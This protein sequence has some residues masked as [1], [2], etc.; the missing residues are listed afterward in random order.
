MQVLPAAEAGAG[1]LADAQ[2]DVQRMSAHIDDVTDSGRG[3]VAKL[4]RPFY[5]DYLERHRVKEP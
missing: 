1:E 5:L 3:E 2:A 4:L